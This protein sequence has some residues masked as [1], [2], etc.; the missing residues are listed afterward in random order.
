MITIKN[1]R[2]LHVLKRFYNNKI[3]DHYES[4]RNV[5]SFNKTKLVLEQG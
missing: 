2:L 1:T 3:I 5:G 4:P